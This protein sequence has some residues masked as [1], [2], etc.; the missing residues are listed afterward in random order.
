MALAREAAG[1]VG[2][3]AMTRAWPD[4]RQRDRC[5]ESLL[6]DGLLVRAGAGY[7][8]ARLSRPQ[9]ATTAS[10]RSL[11]ARR[12]WALRVERLVELQAH[13]R[14]VDEDRGLARRGPA[15]TGPLEVAA[16]PPR[17]TRRWSPAPR[18][19]TARGRTDRARLPRRTT[20]GSAPAG[21]CV[22]ARHSSSTAERRS[23]GVGSSRRLCAERPTRGAQD[24]RDQVVLVVEVVEQHPVAGAERLGERPQAEPDQAVL[25]RVVGRRLGELLTACGH[26]HTLSASIRFDRRM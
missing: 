14:R 13:E 7:A 10:A 23:R 20:A 21:P 22:T 9:R 11:T 12:S 24:R 15:Q 2:A 25:E 1:P 6:A 16:R 26:R 17:P 4:D 5:L 3:R 8:L 18:W 19:R